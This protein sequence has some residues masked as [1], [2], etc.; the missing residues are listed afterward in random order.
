MNSSL[1]GFRHVLRQFGLTRWKSNARKAFLGYQSVLVQPTTHIG[2]HTVLG[3][4]A[5]DSLHEVKDKAKKKA[6]DLAVRANSP[7]VQS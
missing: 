7:S 5:L 3:E 1:T 2:Q 4:K 6:I